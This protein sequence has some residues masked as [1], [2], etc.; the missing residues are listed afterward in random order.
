M[1]VQGVLQLEIDELGLQVRVTITPDGNGTELSP[2]SI[3]AALAEKQVRSGIDTAAIDKAFRALARKKA[4]PA[5][6][7][8]AVGT[9]PQAAEPESIEFEPHPV[10]ERLSSVAAAVLEA[11]P[12][13]RGYVAREEKVKTEKKILKKGAL[14][15]LPSREVVETV[16]EKRTV[17]ENVAIDPTVTETGFVKKGDVV[18]RIK[19]GKPGKPGKSVFGR[20]VPAPRTEGHGFLFCAG[21]AR[22]GSEAV[23]DATG[24]LRRGAAWCDVVPFNDHAV[25]VS[26]SKDG[27]TCLLA[28]TPGDGSAPVPAAAEVMERAA[29]LG[30]APSALLPE[31]EIGVL[32]R[33]AAARGEPSAEMPITPL[34]HGAAVVTVSPDKLKAVLFLRK[35][36]GG[37]RPLT[38][39]GVSEAIRASRVKGFNPAAVRADLLA[40]FSGAAAELADYVLVN[41]TPPK[42]GSEPKLEWRALFLPAEESAA[43]KAAAAANAAGLRSLKSLDAFPLEKVEAVA[44]VKQ[45]AEILRITP[46][47][48]AVPGVDV[49]GAA[50]HPGALAGVNV[51][52]FEGVQLRSGLVS[53]TAA[54]I[55][56]KGSDG[57]AILLRVRPHKDAEMRV[58]LAPDRMGAS[59]SFSPPEGDGLPITAEEARRRIG[60]AG[61]QKGIDEGRLAQA[62]A[63]VARGEPLVDFAFAEGKRP[64]LDVAKRV[65]FHVRL[66]TGKAVS[67]RPDG[68]ADYRAQDRITRVRAGEHIATVKPRD[69]GAEDG[70]DVTGAAVRLAAEEQETL[71]AGHGVREAVQP[72]G[73]VHFITEAAGELARD[74]GLLTV[75]E[76]HEVSGDVGLGTGNIKFPGNVRISGSVR[77]G[78]TVVSGGLLEVGQS[79]EAAL[80]SADGSITVGQGIKGEG[81]AILRSKKDIVSAFTEHSVLLSIG[82]V[83]LRG[84]CVRCQVKCNGRL[85]LDTEK[86]TLVGGEVRASRGVEVQNI[87][88]PGGAHTVVSFGQ[89]FLVKDQVERV[90][91]DV[92]AL[93]KKI[94]DLDAEMFVL[95]RKAA[96]AAAAAGAAA[97]QSQAAAQLAAARGQKVQALKLVEQHKLRLI[98][99]H[100]KYDEHVPSDVVVR[101]TVYPGVVLESHGR[102]WETR[103]EK[104]MITLHFDPTQGRI[105]EK[106]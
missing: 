105:V 78:F 46:V 76:V 67:I 38:P 29:K 4:E 12:V 22:T 95:E 72:D 58:S 91:R 52:L 15:F 35:A 62:L 34:V 100:D 102:R 96:E 68:S 90:E 77:S 54:G 6:F 106:T 73:S 99:L 28:F 85:R 36:R 86:G 82:D 94:A 65:E 14:P 98:T 21:V 17:L 47:V 101:G 79:V 55:L 27:L 43:I 42:A 11:A 53:A 50:V 103:T 19:P 37:G 75:R 16:M 83:R 93:T 45:E 8:A 41:G 9:P 57:D 7:V 56:E 66:A 25:E 61:V 40:F 92:A 80:L 60:E 59:L 5:S 26:A 20:A 70:W 51:R 104:K 63:S 18:A 74:S 3:Q 31:A 23:A 33:K 69:A 84:P 2:E 89:D 44:R 97:G 88:S 71:K 1:A 10:P 39:A 13:A 48:G 24:F 49:F 30:F 87:G 64:A 81:K 32:L